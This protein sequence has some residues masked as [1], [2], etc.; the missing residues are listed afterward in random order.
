MK[1]KDQKSKYEKKIETFDRMLYLI[2]KQGISYQGTQGTAP[3]NDTMWN[4]GT[5]SAVIWQVLH[6]YHFFYEH[7]NSPFWKNLSY[8]S[9]TS[10]NELTGIAAKCILQKWLFL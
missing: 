9:S 7:V 3:S 2:K 4:L 6:C 5:L 8:M 10:Q 1:P